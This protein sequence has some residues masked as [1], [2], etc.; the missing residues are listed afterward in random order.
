M[1]QKGLTFIELMIVVALIFMFAGLALPVTFGFYRESSLGDQ[2]RNLENSLRMAQAMAINGRSES[3]AGVKIEPTEGFPGGW[4]YV[5][6]EGESYESRLRGAD[7]AIPFA[8]A[9]STEEKEI[10]FEK[11]TGLP[12]E[13]TEITLSLGGF[14]A[15]ITI[16][17]QGKIERYATTRL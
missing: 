6:F 5:I 17:A 10:V 1:R 4:R 12:N 16:D 7:M 11:L 14:S 13:A 2:A 8:V 9:L 3:N 15:E